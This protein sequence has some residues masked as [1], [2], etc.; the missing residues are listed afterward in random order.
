MKALLNL[1]GDRANWLAHSRKL[2]PAIKAIL[3]VN[4][5]LNQA[6]LQCHTVPPLYRAGVRYA[7][8]PLNLITF[9]GTKFQNVEEFALIPA[10]IEKGWGDCF[11]D[12]TLLLRE[13]HKLVSV[14]EIKAGEK[15]WGHNGWSTVEAVASKGV[16][17]IDHVRLSNRTTLR[18]THNHYVYPYNGARLRLSE[19]R[20]NIALETPRD[21]VP[22]VGDPRQLRKGP[23]EH[24]ACTVEFQ[25][26]F[27][28]A[29]C[30][31]IQTNDHYVYLPENDVT[32][33]NCDDL[34]PWRCAELRNAGEHAKIRIT[35]REHPLTG[36]KVFHVVVR[37]ENGEV[38]DP[39][40]K[41]GMLG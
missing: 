18:L 25:K 31:D 23:H 3:E 33:S 36:Q 19:L 37:R 27:T 8:E 30:W 24:I 11:P 1:T 38:E 29:P 12:G 16:L 17:P 10:V 40:L 15:I 21:S 39:S 14:S 9:G 41:L 20:P 34:A 13:D 7:E 2:G 22:D 6:Y 5:I 28:E 4:V 35:W 26:A 32:V